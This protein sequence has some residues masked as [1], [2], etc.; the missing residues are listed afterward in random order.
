MNNTSQR[1]GTRGAPFDS[2]LSLSN[3]EDDS[4]APSRF[5]LPMKASFRAKASKEQT[6]GTPIRW[7]LA[8]DVMMQGIVVDWKDEPD[9][10]ITLTVEA[11]APTS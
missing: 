6:I 8:D 4:S 1:Q 3:M 2:L 10:S 5:T 7:R 9:G 11:S